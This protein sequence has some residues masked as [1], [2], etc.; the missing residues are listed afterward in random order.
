MNRERLEGDP[1]MDQRYGVYEQRGLIAPGSSFQCHAVVRFHWSIEC[2]N[3]PRPEHQSY[4]LC[5]PAVVSE[6]GH[7]VDS[8]FASHFYNK[9]GPSRVSECCLS[10][11]RLSLILTGHLG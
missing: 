10:H 8:R 9:F 1:R 5:C 6:N 3:P 11:E 2:C 4:R 7:D